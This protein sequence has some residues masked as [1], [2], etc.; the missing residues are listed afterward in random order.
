MNSIIKENTK[1]S[2]TRLADEAKI[3]IDQNKYLFDIIGIFK[4][5]ISVVKNLITNY[6][7]NLN[8]NNKTIYNLA[9]EYKNQLSSLNSKLKEEINKL[10]KKQDNN[11]NYISQDLSIKIKL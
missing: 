2:I 4:Q 6:S 7:L 10:L 1:E 5:Q 8:Q 9:F 11:I 3:H